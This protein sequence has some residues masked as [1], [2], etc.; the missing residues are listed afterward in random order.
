MR[1]T[2]L[3]RRV[4]LKRSGPISSQ[5]LQKKTSPKKR[6]LLKPRSKTRTAWDLEYRNAKLEDDSL[7]RPVDRPDLIFHKENFRKIQ[8]HHVARR[9][10]N[11]I[12]IYLYV[13]TEFHAWIESHAK[14]SRALGWLRNIGEGYPADPN[15]PR[16]W[17]KGALRNEHL[18]DEIES[19]NQPEP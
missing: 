9:L 14:E 2:P 10:G 17:P 18:L 1:K 8:R 7:Q 15:Q 4:P 6:S 12:L 11:R 16:P 13:T 5:S 19:V 3:V